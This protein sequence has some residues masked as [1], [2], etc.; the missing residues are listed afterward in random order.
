MKSWKTPTPEQIDRTVVLLAQREHLRHFFDRLENPE[1]L[2]PLEKKG[3]FKSPPPPIRDESKGTVS[4]PQWPESGYLARMAKLAPEKVASILRAIPD[5]ENIRVHDDFADAALEMPAELAA[6]FVPNAIKWIQ[7]PFHALLPEKLGALLSRLALSGE[8]DSALELAKAVLAIRADPRKKEKVTEEN[9]FPPFPEPNPLFDLWTYRNIME[10]DIRNLL[11]AAEARALKLLCDL[12]ED[13]VSLSQRADE[14]KGPDDYSYI[15]RPSIDNPRYTVDD[16]RGVLISAVRDAAQQLG[17]QNPAIVPQLIQ[18]L[19]DRKWRVFRRI[20]LHVLRL[21]ADAA[22][23]LVAKRLREPERFDRSDFRREYNLLAKERFAQL[24]TED[25]AKILDWIQKGPNTESFRASWERYHDKPPTGDELATYFKVWQRDRLAPFSADLPQSWK[26]RYAELVSEVGPVGDPEDAVTIWSGSSSPKSA[27][28][29]RTMSIDQLVEYLR[30]WAPDPSGNPFGNT[31]AG[32][33]QAVGALMVSEPER[34]SDEAER[35]EGLDP[36]YVRALLQALAEPAKQKLSINW[37]TVLQLCRWVVNQVRAI[38]DRKVRITDQDPDWGWTRKAIANL[39]SHGFDSDGI[40]LESRSKAWQVLEPLSDDPDPTAEDELRKSA[41]WDRANY[42]INTLRGE[43]LHSVIRYALWVRRHAEREPAGKSRAAQGFDEMP[44]VRTVL[45]KHL[46]HN[47]DPSL[48]IRSVYGQWLPSLVFLDAN[49][50]RQSIPIIFP[51]DDSSKDLRDAA[52]NTY[53][54]YCAPYDE[55]FELLDNQYRQAIDRITIST[56]KGIDRTAPE[57]RLAQHLM[58]E[59]WRGN[60]AEDDPDGLLARF[61]AKADPKLCLR[62]LD[63]VGTSLRN[64]RGAVPAETLERLQKL[65]T[66][67]LEVVRGAD[68]SSPQKEELTAFGWWFASKKFADSWSIEQVLKVLNIAGSIEPDHFVVERLAELA[69]SMPAK[70]ID[71]LALIVEGDKEGWGV[72]SWREHA[73]ILLAKVV[74]SPD[75]TARGSA[76]ELVH[77]LGRRGYPE[78]RD[79]LPG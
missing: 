58:T 72:L 30:S 40:P 67:R 76:I 55:T 26:Q 49:W 32:L 70:A 3:Y 15:W 17:Q 24:E 2:V 71:C 48:A 37:H 28:D 66:K 46:D 25:Q 22:P 50:A 6:E 68:R 53:I 69:G 1:W 42:S 65:W 23:A 75:M 43:A 35:F 73:R 33:G 54:V 14:G 38:S 63:F 18:D 62:A 41:G 11:T 9:K 12:L 61:Y 27:E 60:L 79:L 31:I 57:L 21:F 74:N 7:A 8:V 16:L 34:F 19:E 59:Y 52:W 39:L 78:Y 56:E 5:T 4:F 51:S 10:R 45:D 29:L 13:A 44:E 20:A 47:A 36:T 77:R 64:T